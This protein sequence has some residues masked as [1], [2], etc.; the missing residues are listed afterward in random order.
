MLWVLAASW[1]CGGDDTVTATDATAG[2]V[3][4]TDSDA[5]ASEGDTD[6][7][8]DA[9]TS[10]TS[11]ASDS[12]TTE[13]ST[14]ESSTTE[15]S[16]TAAPSVCGDGV[17]EAPEVCD[18]G[19]DQAHDGCE[20][21]CSS[22]V[23]AALWFD[24]YPG[25]L[26]TFAEATSLTRA[27]TGNIVAA[28]SEADPDP[29]PMVGWL[30]EYTQDGALQRAEAVDL[31]PVADAIAAIETAPNG[32]YV[33]AGWAR[34]P[35]CTD[36]CSVGVVA[37]LDASGAVLWSVTDPN[38]TELYD[39]ALAD[40]GTV[41]AVGHYLEFAWHMTVTRVSPDGALVWSK[42]PFAGLEGYAGVIHAIVVTG[43]DSL[44]VGGLT[45]KPDDPA[46][47]DLDLFYAGLTAEGALEWSEVVDGG[48]GGDDRLNDLAIAPNG[49]IV[50]TGSIAVDVSVIPDP[51]AELVID[52]QTELLWLARAEP[53][54]DLVWST[55]LDAVPRSGGASVAVHPEHI[56][57]AG[58]SAPQEP[59]AP[60][61]A[62]ASFSHDG[63]LR[64]WSA[65]SEG[66]LSS[67]AAIEVVDDGTPGGAVYL[68][69]GR[70]PA[71][72]GRFRGDAP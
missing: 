24:V 33:V 62:V 40:D 58:S 17:V 35:M 3:A 4:A 6:D 53:G 9:T 61:L 27:L 59:D 47:P 67:P 8:S 56:V 65:T 51:Q 60:A 22:D 2:T 29:I 52:S 45:T 20:A 5:T 36:G 11:D 41:Y 16:T 34:E 1:A 44:V 49:D 71:W 14:T 55:S 50:L 72:V 63:A 70:S 54:G 19:N 15:G 10:D 42:D 69:G 23:G 28:G 57:V 21:R 68:A 26:E 66:P 43:D 32:D 38:A 30:R 48:Q 64:W 18:D 25:A 46:P 7:A 37:R 13:G 31:T 12:G 39:L